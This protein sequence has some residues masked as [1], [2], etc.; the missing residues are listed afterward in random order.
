MSNSY[1]N[2][3]TIDCLLNKEALEEYSIKEK[4]KQ[5]NNKEINFYRK[6]IYNLFKELIKKNSTT[7]IPPDIEYAYNTFIKAAIH[8]FKAEDSNDILQEEY[9]DFEVSLDD[10]G[11]EKL[12][13]IDNDN[14]DKL[15]MRSV[16]MDMPTLDKYV[17]RTYVKK[18]ENIILPKPREVDIMKPEFKNKGLKKEKYL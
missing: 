15:L 12:N 14:V 11:D 7:E 3:I 13:T 4:T 5:I 2:Q 17:K 6:R 8:H 18:E 16:K 10:S 9:K 1:I